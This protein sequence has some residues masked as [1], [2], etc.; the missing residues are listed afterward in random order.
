[1]EELL[2]SALFLGNKLDVVDE[3][4]V[5]GAELVA[6]AGHAIVADGVD[7]LVGEFFR[8]DVRDAGHGLAAFYLVTDG[9]HEVGLAHADSAVEEERIVGARG[10]L[11]DGQGGGAG[12]L[13]AIADDESIE[14]IALIELRGSRPVEAL[15]LGIAGGRLGR[16]GRRMRGNGA[17]A[18]IATLRRNR[19]VFLGGDEAHIVKLQRLQVDGFL[20]Q[21]AVLVADV[22]ELG[23]R[24]ADVERA[25]RGVAIARGF[26]PGLERLT[27]DLLFEGGQNLNPGIKDGCRRGCK[28]HRSIPCLRLLIYSPYCL[29]ADFG[30]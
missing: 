21:I 27:D 8:G 19:G 3:Q 23:R 26:E 20:N 2:L 30:Q 15:L 17:E 6:K 11:G 18:A 7:H 16:G 9:V 10:P 29:S 12:K 24:H 22:L 25:A 13:I 28:C 1:M 4:N 14:C 5:D